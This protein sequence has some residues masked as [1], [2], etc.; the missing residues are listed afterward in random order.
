MWV[1]SVLVPTKESDKGGSGRADQKTRTRNRGFI[2]TLLGR[3]AKARVLS[4]TTEYI[5]VSLHLQL[6]VTVMEQELAERWSKKYETRRHNVHTIRS[7]REHG[8]LATPRSYRLRTVGKGWAAM[9]ERILQFL[10]RWM[11]PA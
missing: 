6:K 11:I 9:N 3:S 8:T 4:W 7:F 5:M 10:H 1:G 2:P